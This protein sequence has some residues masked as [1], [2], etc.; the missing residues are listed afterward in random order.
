MGQPRVVIVGGGPGGLSAA[1]KLN[2]SA[3]VT[4]IEA[5]GWHEINW[6]TPRVLTDPA[7]VAQVVHPYSAVPD[8]GRLVPGRVTAVSEST[9]TLE[10]GSRLEFDFLILAPGST[11]PEP[12]IK[13]FAGSLADRKADIQ[14]EQERLRSA[15]SVAIIGGG[16]VG[17]EVAAEI[18][19]DLPGKQV[20]IITSGSRLLA[21]KSPKIGAHAASWIQKKGGKVIYD[22]KVT[23]SPDGGWSLSDGSRLEADVVYRCLG[24][25]PN[26]GFLQGLGILDTQG[27]IKVNDKLQVVGHSN[28]FAV[29]DA[30]D[31]K[32]TKVG[33]LAGEHGKLVAANIQAARA[34]KPLKAWKPNG[35]MPVMLVSLGRKA[36]TGHIASVNLTGCLAWL[37][38]MMKSG[39]LFT[40]KTK[41]D[42]GIKS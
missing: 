16:P 27:A 7:F 20:T 32:E 41:Q 17:V 1:K 25:R 15:S 42:L 19:T 31:V 8:I 2:G 35:G 24:G 30:T 5:K 23:Q 38:A 3:D 10:D 22:E 13:N 18:L 4:L 39:D 14:K 6:A 33:Y 34:G 21:D 40:G 29:G 12:A 36:G 9:V 26:T 28:M 37:P 11:Y